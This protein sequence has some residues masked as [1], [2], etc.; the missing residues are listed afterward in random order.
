MKQFSL[1]VFSLF[2]V[3]SFAQK[4]DVKKAEEIVKQHTQKVYRLHAFVKRNANKEPISIQYD[5]SQND[6]LAIIEVLTDNETTFQV[7]CYE[8]SK[9]ID[10][11]F[12]KIK[13]YGYPSKN[14]KTIFIAHKYDIGAKVEMADEWFSNGLIYFVVGV[15]VVIFIGVYL[16]LFGISKRIRKI[17][18]EAEE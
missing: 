18:K 11:T 6:S 13:F 12:N 8:Y 3:A 10:S 7:I 4:L 2:T 5:A 14:D 17:E 15:L 16:Y 9:V 1:I